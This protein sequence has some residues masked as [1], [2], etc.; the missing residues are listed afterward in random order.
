MAVSVG[1]AIPFPLDVGEIDSLRGNF[2]EKQALLTNPSLGTYRAGQYAATYC[3]PGSYTQNNAYSEFIHSKLI[4]H[5]LFK[6]EVPVFS[7][8]E[9]LCTFLSQFESVASVYQWSVSQKRDYLFAQ[10]SGDAADYV[11]QL[12]ADRTTSYN[13]L[14]TEPE[15]RF[16]AYDSLESNQRRFFS[17]SLST[18]ETVKEY[19]AD[20][21]DLCFKAFPEG[22][23]A[24]PREKLLLR[25]FLDGLNNTEVAFQ[26]D[27][28]HKPT[29]LNQAVDLVQE[30][31]EM[32]N[33]GK[34]ASNKNEIGELCDTVKLLLAVLQPVP[35]ECSSERSIFVEKQKVF[36]KAKVVCYACQQLGH[37]AK[38][39][40]RDSVLVGQQ[41]EN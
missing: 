30:Y 6:P 26:V 39:C 41:S 38:E 35:E 5:E 21:R 3:S 27:F 8:K 12:P 34:Q 7:G 16:K 29:S 25:Q 9:K 19:A 33:V 37:F 24:D 20:L 22:I 13:D 1:T 10:L 4:C 28:T 18:E 31:I 23:D 15:W 11:C 14:I 36:D 32:Q 40:R 2:E 17:R